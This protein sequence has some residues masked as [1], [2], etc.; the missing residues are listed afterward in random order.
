MT[1]DSTPP[2]HD[3]GSV[4]VMIEGQLTEAEALQRMNGRTQVRVRIHGDTL[5]C[6]LDDEAVLDD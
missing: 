3:H 1:A 4:L 2:P 5:V 6:W